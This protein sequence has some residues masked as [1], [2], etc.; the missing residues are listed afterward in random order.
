MPVADRFFPRRGFVD[1]LKRQGDFDELFL[2]GHDNSR[3]FRMISPAH[4]M[5]IGRLC[6]TKPRGINL[7]I[8]PFHLTII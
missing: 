7:T 6:S 3:A 8:M 4:R 5:N 1:C 2:V